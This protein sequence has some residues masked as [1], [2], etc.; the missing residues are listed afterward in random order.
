MLL[1]LGVY[2]I[3]GVFL[4]KHRNEV[5]APKILKIFLLMLYLLILVLIAYFTLFIFIF[6]YN[7]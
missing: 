5:L 2:I 3:V 4:V 1:I 6:G 7:S